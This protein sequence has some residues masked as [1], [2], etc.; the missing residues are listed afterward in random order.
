MRRP[1]LRT[2]YAF[3][4]VAVAASLVA[5][6]RPA[7]GFIVAERW[8]TTAAGDVGASGAPIVLTWS[9]VP[10]G[11]PIPDRPSS[12]LVAFLD[13]AFNVTSRSRDLTERPWFPLIDS[14]FSRWEA[15]GGVKFTYEAF[16]D[17]ALHQQSAGSLGIRGDI[18]L[19]AAP[20]DGPGR[21]LASSQYPNGGDIVLDADEASRFANAEQGF[22]RFRNTLMH[23]IGHTLGLDHVASSDANFL[24]ESTLS[25]GIDGPQFDEIRG[26][27]YLYGDQLERANNR[28]GND[29]ASFA[30]PLGL[31]APG[32]VATLGAD[33]LPAGVVAPA[34]IDFL[35]ISNRTDV[36]FFSFDVDRPALVDVA[37][38]PRGERFRQG[39]VG[40]P[41][42]WI[43][44]AASNDLSFAIFTAD[45]TQLVVANELPRGA[46]EQ[47]EGLF[48]PTAGR[49]YIR[50]SGSREA[51]QLYELN[52]RRHV[53]ATPEPAVVVTAIPLCCLAILR[54]SVGANRI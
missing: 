44:A 54:R 32:D 22:L 12:T 17:G 10:D 48:L 15:L 39:S 19:A 38:I 13:Q 11:T 18:R 7:L 6:A 37:L 34:A 5:M 28:A 46:A 26:L 33:P 8:S 47:V 40:E 27:H 42:I 36:D 51:V 53:L 20:G 50:V 21:T 30:F 4:I 43:E 49:Y 2:D 24:M 31:L 45:Q 23:E 16:D 1:S 9:L 52:A 29:S 14:A 35:S 41:E 25:V 3:V